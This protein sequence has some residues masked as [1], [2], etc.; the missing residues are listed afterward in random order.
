VPTI[1]LDR[2]DGSPPLSLRWTGHSGAALRPG[3]MG[4]ELPPRTVKTRPRVGGDGVDVERVVVG[5]RELTFPLVVEGGDRAQFRDRRR[6]VQSYLTGRRGVRVTHV[7]DDGEE[8][9][10]HG[11]YVGGMEGEHVYDGDTIVT[12]APVLRCGD[13]YW[14]MAEVSEPWRPGGAASWFPFPPLTLTGSILTARRD[15]TNPGDVDSWPL[16]TVTG[17]GDRLDVVHRSIDVD[18]R[19]I[20]RTI[21]YDAPIPAGQVVKIDTR[22]GSRSVTDA[23]GTNLMPNVASDPEFWPLLGGT[24]DVELTMPGSSEDS[25]VTVTWTPLRESV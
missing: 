11:Y 10:T 4:L 7:E 9:W 19:E 17:P 16:W 12:Y 21:V 14:H 20:A 23:A 24:N 15:V 3:A 8:M 5:M 13:P 25:D 22:P 6:R 18:G 2:L 1:I